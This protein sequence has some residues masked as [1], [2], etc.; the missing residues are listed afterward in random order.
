MDTAGGFLYSITILFIDFFVLDMLVMRFTT[1]FA[2]SSTTI[3]T[4]PIFFAITNPCRKSI[5]IGSLIKNVILTHQKPTL[6]F[7]HIILQYTIYQMFYSFI[8]NIKIIYIQHIKIIYLLKT[9]QYT[10][11]QPQQ[12]PPTK[13]QE[14]AKNYNHNHRSSNKFQ[15]QKPQPKKKKTFNKTPPYTTQLATTIPKHNLPPPPTGKTH[16]HQQK[17]TSSYHHPILLLKKSL[18]S[19]QNYPKKKSLEKNQLTHNHN[20][21][22]STTE[23]K[24]KSESEISMATASS[25]SLNSTV[26]AD[27][28]GNSL[29]RVIGKKK[30]KR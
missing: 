20:H 5:L 13:N 22:E 18:K 26:T 21:M 19:T 11:T 29:G 24:K 16:H 3:F 4:T 23:E 10:N 6:L 17:S 27:L 28:N 12:S 15:I 25:V 14:P 1:T 30:K 7:Y 2:S 8:L 9:Q